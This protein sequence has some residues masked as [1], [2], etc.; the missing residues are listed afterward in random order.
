MIPILTFTALDWDMA[1][2]ELEGFQNII[3]SL[4]F[5]VNIMH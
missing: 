1:M 5:N 2:D 3:L 4:P